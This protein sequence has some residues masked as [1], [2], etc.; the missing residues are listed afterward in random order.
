VAVNGRVAGVARAYQAED[1]RSVRFS[2][3]VPP[4]AFRAGRNEVAFYAAPADGPVATRLRGLE[5]RLSE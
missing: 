4:A 3:L 1:D 5:T 2:V